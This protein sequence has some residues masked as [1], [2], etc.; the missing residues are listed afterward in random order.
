M[1]GGILPLLFV[2]LMAY[3]FVPSL[4]AAPIDTTETTDFSVV[5]QFGGDENSI[6][7]SDGSIYRSIGSRVFKQDPS[8]LENIVDLAVSIPL[9]DVI[10]SLHVYSGTV[11]AT[12]GGAVTA[13]SENDLSV[14]STI[15]IGGETA[16]MAHWGNTLYVANTENYWGEGGVYPIDISNPATMVIGTQ[17]L[18]EQGNGVQSVAVTANNVLLVGNTS[19]YLRGYDLNIDPMNPPQTSELWTYGATAM[20]VSGTQVFAAT[21]NNAIAYIEY[22]DAE[23]PA[24][25]ASH[26]VTNHKTVVDIEIGSEEGVIYYAINNDWGYDYNVY[27]VTNFGTTSEDVI[28]LGYGTSDIEV[29]GSHILLA[30]G[31]NGSQ[32]LYWNGTSFE[33][34]STTVGFSNPGDVVV[35]DDGFIGR[36]WRSLVKFDDQMNVTSEV[37]PTT[38]FGSDAMTLCGENICVGTYQGVEVFNQSLVYQSS[39][40]ITGESAEALAQGDGNLYIS[41]F[42]SGSTLYKY[43]LTTS[44]IISTSI[45]NGSVRDME[46]HDGFVYLMQYS[47][48]K[49][50]D[51]NLNL[52]SEISKPTNTG[53][54]LDLTNNMLGWSTWCT[55]SDCAGGRA[56]VYDI[57]DPTEPISVTTADVPWAGMGFVWITPDMFLVSSDGKVHQFEIIDGEAISSGAVTVAGYPSKMHQMM[58]GDILVRAQDGGL[59]GLN[60]D[61]EPAQLQP[62]AA[63]ITE[64]LAVGETVTNTLVVTNTGEIGTSWSLSGATIHPD[65]LFIDGPSEG[66]LAA[67]QT[68]TVTVVFS[69]D[70]AE[71]DSFGA[72]YQLHN[73]STGEIHLIGFYLEV[74]EL[75]KVYLPIIIK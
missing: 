3:I 37:T 54:Q 42:N 61:L 59:Y 4:Q 34:Q 55:G 62:S 39:I 22:A 13:I 9:T 7:F 28:N 5:G 29:I 2:V 50:F 12:H 71:P 75:Q 65:Q 31:H 48:V 19:Y 52:V 43:N 60:L 14:I 44:A 72:V 36:T 23:N 49:I 47:T 53:Y 68:T 57:T 27:A 33:T 26:T 38:I 64:T 56:Y 17:I 16:E 25:L 35:T 20:V 69:A 58:N 45:G 8:D 11:Y 70:V 15:E 51:S 74:V 10:E 40:L 63:V 24:V 32:V 41:A 66:Y 73:N 21:G 6:E 18:S 30:N 46:F 67:G 1:L